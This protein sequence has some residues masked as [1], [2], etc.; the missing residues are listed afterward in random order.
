MMTVRGPHSSRRPAEPRGRGYPKKGVCWDPNSD[1][2]SSPNTLMRELRG[3]ASKLSTPEEDST[4]EA[5]RPT[6]SRGAR[7]FLKHSSRLEKFRDS[8]SEE[9][10]AER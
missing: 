3:A 8:D 10:I 2:P 7:L 4:G 1:D 9:S 6:T 5:A